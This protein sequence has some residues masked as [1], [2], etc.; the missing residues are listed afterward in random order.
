[1]PRKPC[2]TRAKPTVAP[3]MLCVPDTGRLKNVATNNHMQQP[4]QRKI[5]LK[6]IST[7]CSYS[8]MMP[9][10]QALVLSVQIEVD[11]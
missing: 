2:A 9:I 7:N 10:D 3:T 11:R 5:Q 1:M 8:L 4:R 6:R